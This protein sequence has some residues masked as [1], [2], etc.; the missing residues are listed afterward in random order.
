VR[1]AIERS[2]G[3]TDYW[4]LRPYLSKQAANYV[5]T[6]I[7]YNYLFENYRKYGII[8]EKSKFSFNNTDTVKAQKAISLKEVA[9]ILDIRYDELEFLNPEYKT[10]IIPKNNPA[11]YLMLPKNKIGAFV[12][13]EEKIYKSY[14]IKKTYTEIAKNA[15]ETLGRTYI[16]YQVKEGEYFHKLALKYNCTVE[17]IKAWNRLDSN[18][19]YSGQKIKI[20]IE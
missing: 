1:K 8:P 13:N 20:W 6:F 15:G 4:K 17:D 9:K 18:A 11:N 14:S 12:R 7:A 10:G 3:E 2:G 16:V 5:S 19:L